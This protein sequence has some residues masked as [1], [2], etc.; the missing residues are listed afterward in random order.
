MTNDEILLLLWG[1]GPSSDDVS[2]ES[3]IQIDNF[4]LDMSYIEPEDG[5]VIYF[6]KPGWGGPVT[7]ET[8]AARMAGL[9]A[10]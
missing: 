4:P 8:E 9:K 7:Q 10:A 6:S 3:K 1:S 5:Q 2:V